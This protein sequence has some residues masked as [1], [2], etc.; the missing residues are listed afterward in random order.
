MVVETFR[1][2]SGGSIEA[3]HEQFGLRAVRSLGKQIYLEAEGVMAQSA[4][5]V[6][7][8]TGT[9]RASG[10]VEHPVIDGSNVE[11]RFGYGGPAAK[12]NPKTGQSADVYALKVHEDLQALHRVGQA[13]FLEQPFDAAKAK[14]AERVAA[15]MKED[16]HAITDT[17]LPDNPD[18]AA[19]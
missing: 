1:L 16:L 17:T 12:I 5:L 7:V 13:K 19:Q 4:P 2:A 6:P 3:L 15:G 10:F 14:M 18:E 9:L 8:D 11:V